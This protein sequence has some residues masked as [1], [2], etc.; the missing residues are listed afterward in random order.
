MLPTCM[1]YK[2]PV[3]SMSAPTQTAYPHKLL[4]TTCRFPHL[5]IG[6]AEHLVVQRR[7]QHPIGRTIEK[8]HA[9]EGWYEERASARSSYLRGRGFGN[10]QNWLWQLVPSTTIEDRTPAASLKRHVAATPY[11]PR[12]PPHKKCH[13][14]A[15]LRDSNQTVYKIPN[16]MTMWGVQNPPTP[17]SIVLSNVVINIPLGG[18]FLH[19]QPADSP[20][21][22]IPIPP[23]AD[24]EC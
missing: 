18:R 6:N 4:Q 9:K 23:P 17:V 14:L 19:H 13:G 15:K 11:M 12:A 24:W 2:L 16:Y 10:V 21:C 3:F 1:K 7:D 5:Q 8:N 22:P 20:S